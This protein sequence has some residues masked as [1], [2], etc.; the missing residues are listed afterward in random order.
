MQHCQKSPIRKLIFFLQ[1]QP[2]AQ[3]VR[4]DT[5]VP[6]GDMDTYTAQLLTTEGERIVIQIAQLAAEMSVPAEQ[7][8]EDY[9]VELLPLRCAACYNYFPFKTAK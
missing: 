3:E 1:Y 4:Q 7:I 5:F 6:V 9:L 2:P 8:N